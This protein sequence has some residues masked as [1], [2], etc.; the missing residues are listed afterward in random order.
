MPQFARRP[1]VPPLLGVALIIVALAAYVY[2]VAYP[3]VHGLVV[4]PAFGL[5]RRVYAAIPPSTV[6][7]RV[8]DRAEFISTISSSTSSST[9]EHNATSNVTH[10]NVTNAT[11]SVHEHERSSVPRAIA[12]SADA[13]ACGL[14]PGDVLFYTE[15]RTAIEDALS[16][17]LIAHT[18][19][20]CGDIDGSLRLAHLT[21]S[22]MRFTRLTTLL[23]KGGSIFVRKL[24]CPLD[25]RQELLDACA[26]AVKTQ[27]TQR[28]QTRHGGARY[29]AAWNRRGG[30][31]LF[32]LGDDPTLGFTCTTATL[33]LLE[34][35]RILG[36]VD[37]VAF[38][39]PRSLIEEPH[40]P[41]GR[42]AWAPECSWD[43][44]RVWVRDVS[45]HHVVTAC[46][47]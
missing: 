19:I 11:L 14:D 28:T 20:V 10:A 1:R 4:T 35:A 38:M 16:T 29:S 26:H 39:S 41:S 3:L 45:T 21:V 6:V 36:P 17:P 34:E 30:R 13:A 25:L 43:P 18:T 8:I 12:T 9:T 15:P 46:A 47:P 2:F 44:L 7:P 27:T 22:G 5:P 24:H 32:G 23:K 42:L 31:I 37:H 33:Q 40:G